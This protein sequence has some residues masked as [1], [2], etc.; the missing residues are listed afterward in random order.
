[1][2]ESLLSPMILLVRSLSY[3]PLHMLEKHNLEI[4]S[5]DRRPN[6]TCF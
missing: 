3:R 1:M 5:Y 4:V 6:V 2:G